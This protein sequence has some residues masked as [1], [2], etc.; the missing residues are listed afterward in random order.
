[1]VSGGK[2]Q[3]V[4]LTDVQIGRRIICQ[5]K[6]PRTPAKSVC[7]KKLAATVAVAKKG[8]TA[9]Q[10]KLWRRMVFAPAVLNVSQFC[11]IRSKPSGCRPWDISC[12]RRRG[13]A[14]PYKT[15]VKKVLSGQLR[16]M[17]IFGGTFLWTAFLASGRKL[18][19]GMLK[20][21]AEPT[22]GG[23]PGATGNDA[24]FGNGNPYGTNPN[25]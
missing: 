4:A 16:F 20:P 12:L 14:M 11:D 17:D 1:M 2:T 6:N 8:M 22:S 13:R 3:T 10:L 15:C 21:A 9:E 18:I 23:N 24:I 25:E 7:A 19:T 5:E